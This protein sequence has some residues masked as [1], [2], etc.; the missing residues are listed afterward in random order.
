MLLG[1]A[2]ALSEETLEEI[3]ATYNAANNVALKIEGDDSHAVR[4]A[5]AASPKSPPPPH[6]PHPPP[7]QPIL[8]VLVSAEGTVAGGL[9]V[10]SAT[11]KLLRPAHRRGVATVV[12][13]SEAGD[14]AAARDGVLAP[15]AEPLRGKLGAALAA[16]VAA[17]YNPMRAGTTAWARGSE[18]YSGEGGALTAIT[19]VTLRNLSN[20]WSG[21][22]RGR[23]AVAVEAGGG[24]ATVSGVIRVVTHYFESGNTQM[25]TERAVA[26]TR[27]TWAAG[28]A[29][30]GAKALTAVIAAAEDGLQASLDE[31]YESLSTQALKEMRRFLPVSGQKMNWN[32]AE[33]R[34]RRTL[35]ASSA[36][37][38]AGGAGGG[39]K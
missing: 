5:A 30:A 16:H 8:Q 1:E 39:A 11:G 21:S 22:W 26:A 9:L 32:V 23:Y 20:F 38:G 33:I 27:V 14:A 4:R 19:A 13:D 24:A 31:M 29:A 12:D 28:D 34:M 36:G 6:H 37:G 10:D 35:T 2:G 17:C 7:A 25:H 18:V 15:A 3:Y